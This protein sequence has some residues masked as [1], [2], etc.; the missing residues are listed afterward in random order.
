[1]RTV[2]S[3]IL[4]LWRAGGP[5]IGDSGAPHGR[6][7]VEPAWQLHT[8]SSVATTDPSK[9][10]FRWFQRLD[11][12][13]TEV[14]VPNIKSI[15]I[16][17]NLDVDAATCEIQIYNQW[18]DGNMIHG[19]NTYELGSPGY[20]TWN[21]GG[22]DAQAR[23]GHPQNM[24]NNILI[25]NALL[26]T[27]Q[28]YGG[29]TKTVAQAVSDGNILLTGLWLVDEVTVGTDGMLSL[30]CRDM[31]KLLIEQQLYPPLMPKGK[32]PL[33]YQRWVETTITVP[34]VPVYDY[35]DPIEMA[36]EGWPK[37]ITDLAISADGKGYWLVG[38]DGG[39][40]SFNVPFYGSRGTELEN[41]KMST[42]C[43]DPL[44]RGY[45]L[46]GEDGGVFT[47]GEVSY[48]GDPVGHTVSPIWESAVSPDGRG[49]AMIDKQGHVY[50]YGS[51]PYLGGNPVGYS[52]NVVDIAV[53]SSGQGYWL[54][55][56]AGDIYTYGDAPYHGGIQDSGLAFLK[57]GRVVG[58]ASTPTDGGYWMVTETGQRWHFGDAENLS[59]NGA[60]WED[61][62]ANLGDPIFDMTA[63]ASG[64]GYL[65]VGGNGE[66]YS[67]G[68]APFWGSL[69][70]DFQYTVKSDG[71]YKDYSDIVK[72]LLRW[73][74]FLAYGNG[75]DDVYGNIETTGAFAEDKLDTA[76]FD[77]KPVID[78]IN[79]LKEIVGYHCWVDEE[80]AVHFESPNWYTYGNLD[81]NG[82]RLNTIPEID[83]RY[84]LSDYQVLF[85]DQSTRSELIIS[86][87][88]PTAGLDGTVTTRRS[89]TS[90]PIT[91]LLLR[92]MVRPAMWVNEFFTNAQEQARMLERLEDHIIMSYRQGS[93][94]FIA[95]PQIQINDQIR[96]YE[97]QTGE[98][99][100][101][102]VRG[103]RSQMDLDT[104]E[105]MMTA[106]TNW[107]GDQLSSR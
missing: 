4:N 81:E 20:F 62:R 3:T 73:S 40:F 21:Y 9:L 50:A 15:N 105:W 96:I 48:Y 61:V 11:N 7:T 16:D 100:L 59:H 69:P 72:D 12:S 33:A 89:L 47:F 41:A 101:H 66:V 86:S 45:W 5:F 36:P 70:E 64:H 17:R 71:N 82:N 90:Q 46:F 97:R 91:G 53:T 23:W 27:Y 31:M 98:T 88:D 92:G 77:K 49:Y 74:G 39:V 34:G 78:G 58:M 44:N 68:D 52:G 99:Y 107:L 103:L 26:R 25:P 75:G 63:T 14:E 56:E 102:Y 42:M 28:G 1:M 24:W 18:M 35:T 43:A 67:F 65:L 29:K 79:S 10:P 106:Q 19:D 32:F 54:V 30:K 104:G 87:S 22:P 13:Q 57:D 95:N 94:S 6:V 93:V 60:D 38:T 55:D 83:E 8:T 2:S 76:L 80:G 85:H 37:Y 51:F 84:N